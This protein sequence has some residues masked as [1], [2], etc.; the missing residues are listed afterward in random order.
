MVGRCWLCVTTSEN[1]EKC[2]EFMV[3]GAVD[4]LENTIKRVKLN[5]KL[6]IYLTGFKIAGI[7]KVSKEYFHNTDRIWDDRIYPHRM[8]IIPEILPH[9]PVNIRTLYYQHFPDVASQGYFRTAV[10]EISEEEFQIFHFLQQALPINY[11]VLQTGGGEYKDEP[12]KRYHFKE[13][14]PGYVQLRNSENR[15]KYVYYENGMFYGKGEIGEITSYEEEGTIYYY[16]EVKNYE[17]IGP[18]KFNEIANNLSIGFIGQAGIRKISK[19]D[20]ETIISSQKYSFKLTEKDFKACRRSTEKNYIEP[21]YRKFKEQ[22]KP[23]LLSA[24]GEPFKDF[25]TGPSHPSPYV[26]RP[27]TRRDGGRY[28]DN[29]WLGMAHKSYED[30]R[31]GIQLQFGINSDSV[32]SFGIWIEGDQA[33]RAR[34]VV[35]EFLRTK[36]QRFLD[37]MRKLDDS[38]FIFVGDELFEANE[39]TENDLDVLGDLIV[40]E[41][42]FTIQRDLSPKEA[43]EM[44]T[45]IMEHIADTFSELLPLYHFL[46]GIEAPE[47]EEIELSED[48]RIIYYHLIAGKN[49]VLIG[50]PGT[51]KTRLAKKTAGLFCG[52]D[53]Y[54]LVTANAE[55]S[56]YNV[57]GGDVISGERALGTD[58]RKGFLSRVAEIQS[59]R[60]HWVIIDEL[61]RANLD[62]AYGEAFTLLDIEHLDKP[63]VRKEDYPWASSLKADIKL[64]PT[65]RLIATMNSYDRAVLFS[66]GYAF[67]RRFAFVEVPSP[68]L[69]PMDAE[70]NIETA[71]GKWRDPVEAKSRAYESVSD[72]ISRWLK[73]DVESREL[74][75]P[76][77]QYTEFEKGLQETW[78]R[79]SDETV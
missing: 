67:R 78:S 66:L 49:I 68:Y 21:V 31:E 11:F 58:F 10:R 20:Y 51:G 8:G 76:Q 50:A 57:V 73:E 61:N 37:I 1:W 9:K 54:D 2:L 36:K 64:A 63:L 44:G 27:F 13:G 60:P 32:F 53:N 5:D 79:V 4:R 47:I 40:D 29:M 46:S 48:L 55:W 17:K 59:E 41:K 38:Y 62:L 77:F 35:A 34:E 28:R 7:C 56:A 33:W 16:A 23:E 70:Y 26:A 24:L 42:Y 14:I 15:A 65:F 19:E 30:P 6:V 3:W 22:L 71:E 39:L 75:H 72:E 25:Q 52:E 69:P 74:I 43:I 12:D 45:S 18:I